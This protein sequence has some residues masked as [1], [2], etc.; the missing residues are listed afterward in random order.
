MSTQHILQESISPHVDI[1]EPIES[2]SKCDVIVRLTKLKLKIFTIFC[3]FK[4]Y[5]SETKNFLNCVLFARIIPLSESNRTQFF[6]QYG[7][8]IDISQ[9]TLVGRQNIKDQVQCIG[10]LKNFIISK[11]KSC[12]LSPHSTKKNLIAERF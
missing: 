8:G 5:R 1:Y 3:S 11:D 7:G 6:Y 4:S 12:T 9:T 10:G 2:W